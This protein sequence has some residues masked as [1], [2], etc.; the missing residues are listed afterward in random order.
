MSEQNP[1]HASVSAAIAAANQPIVNALGQLAKLRGAT[2]PAQ[3]APAPQPQGV[4]ADDVNRILQERLHQQQQQQRQ[5]QVQQQLSQ[6]QQQQ[7][8]PRQPTARDEFIAEQQARPIGGLDGVPPEY[9]KLIGDD[10][11]RWPRE[12][13]LARLT[14]LH[15]TKQANGSELMELGVATSKPAR[16]TPTIS[17]TGSLPTG[18]GGPNRAA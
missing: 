9:Q 13:R 1:F 7:N 4:T 12:A 11:A 17:L 5:D 6:L 10:P 3:P 14:W 18:G 2:P 16:E 15:D 8:Q